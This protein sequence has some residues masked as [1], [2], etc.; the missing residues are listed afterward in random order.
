MR[1]L[2]RTVQAALA[3]A[4]AACTSRAAGAGHVTSKEERVFR[5]F[6]DLPQA[7]YAP[8]WAV[9]QSGSLATVFGAAGSQL[10]ARDK[11]RAAAV[12]VA[13]VGVWGGVKLIKPLVGRGRPSA[14]LDAVNVRG[15]AQSGLGYPSG[16]SAVAATVALALTHGQSPTIKTAALGVAAL[17]GGARMYVGAHLPL[18]IL[19]GLAIGALGG[20]LASYAINDGAGRP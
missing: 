14:E 17:T 5:S 9:M 4:V 6:N 15:Q 18:D 13:G 3:V 10:R 7:L 12:L 1:R 2:T 16:H 20:G 11:K 19:G 8:V